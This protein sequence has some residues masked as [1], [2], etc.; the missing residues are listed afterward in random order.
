MPGTPVTV[1]AASPDHT[2][3]D[4]T[5]SPPTAS[6][7]RTC[8]SR[9]RSRGAATRSNRTS[10]RWATTSP[11]RRPRSRPD[12]SEMSRVLFA[13]LRWCRSCTGW[14]CYSLTRTTES[15]VRLLEAYSS[16]FAHLRTVSDCSSNAYWLAEPDINVLLPAA[17]VATLLRPTMAVALE[18][19]T[20][21]ARNVP[22]SAIEP[23][24][25]VPRIMLIAV[26]IWS[27]SRATAPPIRL[28]TPWPQEGVVTTCVHHGKMLPAA[29]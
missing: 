1:R 16:P 28:I 21:R 10:R 12:R 15:Q 14:T 20:F 11:C 19:V 7:G 26:S 27:D 17:G 6:R 4:K 3:R 24:R 29:T 8:G 18:P 5:R 13:G 23:R 2:R 9:W 25:T 22:A